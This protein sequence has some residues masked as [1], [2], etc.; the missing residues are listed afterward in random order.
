MCKPRAHLVAPSTSQDSTC[1]IPERACR[2]ENEENEE[3]MFVINNKIHTLVLSKRNVLEKTIWALSFG[4]CINWIYVL[5]PEEFETVF[6]M[7]K[8]L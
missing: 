3:N 7:M 2:A 1:A 5:F 6:Q 4:D 8:I